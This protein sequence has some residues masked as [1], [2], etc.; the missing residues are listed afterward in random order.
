MKK[1]CVKASGMLW[2]I[3]VA[4]CGCVQD[5]GEGVR[6]ELSQQKI[7]NGVED[8]MFSAVKTRGAHG[9]WWV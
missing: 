7:V 1:S 6:V 4:L 8:D 3:G 2:C 5:E 9:R